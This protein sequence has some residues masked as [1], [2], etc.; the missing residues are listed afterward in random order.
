MRRRPVALF[1][2]EKSNRR[3]VI[4][5]VSLRFDYS[6]IRLY[7]ESAAK[8][9]GG[10]AFRRENVS[11]FRLHVAGISGRQRFS[12]FRLHVAGIS[13]RLCDAARGSAD[14]RP[15]LDA[16][17]PKSEK[18][19]ENRRIAE[20]IGPVQNRSIHGVPRGATKNVP[21]GTTYRRSTWNADKLLS[22]NN[23]S[24]RRRDAEKGETAKRSGQFKIGTSPGFHVEQ[25]K[26][27]HVERLQSIDFQ[28]LNTL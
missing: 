5:P 2:P 26:T 12:A 3:N 22:F 15:T 7:V 6:S 8:R 17:S 9:F 27:F 14:R 4:F 19:G 16:E 28:Q 13:G 24:P 21:R 18:T 20:K 10:K 1:T 23:L 11:A 25:L